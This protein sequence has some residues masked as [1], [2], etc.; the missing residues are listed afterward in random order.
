MFD[1]EEWLALAAWILIVYWQ[2][3]RTR[4]RRAENDPFFDQS[5]GKRRITFL[6]PPGWLFGVVW[7]I[8]YA[9]MATSIFIYWARDA[10]TP[11]TRTMILLFVNLLLNKVWTVAFNTSPVISLP[12]VIG[13]VITNVWI[14]VEY[15]L[16]EDAEVS[17]W[18]WLAYT[19]WTIY[20]TV[21]NTAIVIRNQQ[22]NRLK[23]RNKS[24]MFRK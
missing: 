23:R 4:V 24:Q 18:L 8:L 11:E 9:L 13:I 22:L 19:V 1:R 20:A 7:T 14:Q 17:F 5:T 10:Q 2:P 21:L 12:I 16:Q 15:W 6:S 3:F